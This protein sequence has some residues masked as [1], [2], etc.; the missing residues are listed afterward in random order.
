MIGWSLESLCSA[1]IPDQY[2]KIDFSL[3]Y[4]LEVKESNAKEGG[5]KILT[6]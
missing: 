6:Q 4:V 1:R 3:E 2:I 5:I